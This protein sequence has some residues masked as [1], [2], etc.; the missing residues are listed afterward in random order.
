MLYVAGVP[1]Q[2]VSLPMMAPGAGGGP[3]HAARLAAG[4][5]P[6]AFVAATVTLPPAGP[7]VA[8]MEVL[9]EIPVHPPGN[10]QA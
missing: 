1:A 7:A 8:V 2:A 4:D 5:I 9:L 3:T 10:V 6:Q